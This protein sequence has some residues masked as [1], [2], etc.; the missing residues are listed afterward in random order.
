[1]R[2]RRSGSSSWRLFLVLACSTVALTFLSTHASAQSSNTARNSKKE[3]HFEV[4]SIHPIK[5]GWTPYD[6]TPLPVSNTAP[7][8]NGFGSTLT[9][10]QML[11][12]AYAPNDQSWPSIQVVNAP[13]WFYGVNQT[14]YAINARVADADVKFWRN[15]SNH[16]ELLRVAMQDL[17]QKR[18]KL[19]LHKIPSSVPDY[20]L[21]VRKSGL[22]MQTATPG[23]AVPKGVFALHSGGARFADG[24][25]E[26]PTWHYY[27]APISDLVEFLNACTQQRPIHDETGLTGRYNFSIKMIDHASHDRDEQVYNWPIDSLGLAL[28]PGKSPGFKL[29]IDHLERP[30]SND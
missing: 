16:H 6:K 19:A 28:K 4:I 13:Q 11:M 5:P 18:C 3:I 15:Q 17:L 25:R 30:S 10:W 27:N 12:I 21:L 26:K 22:K 20:K 9:L 7:S 14:W 1:M 29:A 2:M 23:A 24:P 8:P